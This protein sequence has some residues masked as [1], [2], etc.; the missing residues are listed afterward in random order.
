[1]FFIFRHLQFFFGNWQQFN[2]RS[3]QKKN[4]MFFFAN[5][6]PKLNARNDGLIFTSNSE[7]KEQTNKEKYSFYHSVSQ[8]HIPVNPGKNTKKTHENDFFGCT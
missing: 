6:Q 1:M 3:G 4:H 8:I 2:A 7:Q 5:A